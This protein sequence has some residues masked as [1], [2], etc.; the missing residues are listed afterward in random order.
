MGFL[1]LPDL[2]ELFSRTWRGRDRDPYRALL[3]NSLALLTPPSEVL[4]QRSRP[5]LLDAAAQLAYIGTC[6]LGFI[7]IVPLS[8]LRFDLNPR[9]WSR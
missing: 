8:N 2:V 3:A 4:A 9:R 6:L 5:A 1:R 7:F